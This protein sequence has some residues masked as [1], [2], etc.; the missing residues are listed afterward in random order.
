MRGEDAYFLGFGEGVRLPRCWGVSE[1]EV[2]GE[3]EW[4][5]PSASP[6]LTA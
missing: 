2:E 1:G 6:V 4:K 5:E 3:V